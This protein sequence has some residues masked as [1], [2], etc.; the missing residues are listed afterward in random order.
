MLLLLLPLKKSWKAYFTNLFVIWQKLFRVV[1]A[2]DGDDAT[3]AAT[4]MGGGIDAN[5]GD[6]SDGVTVAFAFL[7]CGQY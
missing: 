2:N 5:V 4:A 6:G 1:H 3:D 7:G